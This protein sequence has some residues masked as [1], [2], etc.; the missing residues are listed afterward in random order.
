MP[1]SITIVDR[2]SLTQG[3]YKELVLDPKQTAIT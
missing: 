3:L 1:A 2:S